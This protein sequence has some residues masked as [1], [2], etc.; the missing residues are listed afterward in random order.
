MWPDEPFLGK[1]RKRATH[2]VDEGGIDLLGEP[3]DH[4]TV[5]LLRTISAGKK[6]CVLEVS[7]MIHFLRDGSN[8]LKLKPH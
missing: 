6:I 8:R 7:E 2:F 4:I 5:Q 3:C 1:S